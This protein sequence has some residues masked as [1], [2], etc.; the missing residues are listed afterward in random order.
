MFSQYGRVVS[1][2]SIPVFDIICQN[3]SII[4][5]KVYINDDPLNLGVVESWDP[6]SEMLKVSIA[7]ELQVND[8]VGKLSSDTQ[9][10]IRSKDDFDSE[11][12]IGSGTTIINGWQR[13]VMGFFNEA[14]QK[15]HQII[16]IIKNSHILLD[17]KSHLSNG[18]LQ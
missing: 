5:E 14:T 1:R 13:S 17:Q 12:I 4:G 15:S 10:N 8:T 11:I 7:K 16:N 2:A 6:L 18:I 9:G 3:I